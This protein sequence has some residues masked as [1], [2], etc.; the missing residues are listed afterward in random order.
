MSEQIRRDLFFLGDDIETPFGAIRF[1]KYKEYLSM[2]V[3]LNIISM[4]ILHFY[5]S[6]K[7]N[8]NFKLANDEDKAQVEEVKNLSLYEFILKAPYYTN[9][10]Y[11]VFK[12]VLV[13]HENL[14]QIF[15]S[16]D[17]FMGLRS[18]VMDMNV[19]IE[20]PSS[21]LEEIQDYYDIRRQKQQKEAGEQD[22]SDVVSSIV[23][24][25][26][27]SWEEV[28]DMTVIQ[29]NLMYSRIA[30][31]KNFDATILFATTNSE[32]KIEQ[33][34]KHID[35]YSKSDLGIEYGQFNK[36]YRGLFND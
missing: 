10:Y 29:V 31:F 14:E 16:E 25:S 30:A 36:K 3:E 5:W 18:L 15:D 20:S 33:W 13:N 8:D 32:H 23:V 12:K 22:V 28:G 27:H 17:L 21:P 7:K 24:G 2:Q 9:A 35:L 19:L 34:S 26:P 6:Y 4:N 11:T 1:L